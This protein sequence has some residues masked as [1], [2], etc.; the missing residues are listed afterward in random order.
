MTAWEDLSDEEQQ[1]I[2]DEQVALE[3][4]LD[5]PIARYKAHFRGCFGQDW[6]RVPLTQESVDVLLAALAGP[7]CHDHRGSD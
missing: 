7:S 4:A 2:S 5:S 1:K 6:I 3:D